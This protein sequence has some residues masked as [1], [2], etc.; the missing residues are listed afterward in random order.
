MTIVRQKIMPLELVEIH[1]NNSD[2]NLIDLAVIAKI[3]VNDARSIMEAHY[4]SA[5]AAKDDRGKFFAYPYYQLEKKR[6]GQTRKSTVDK[7]K[8]GFNRQEVL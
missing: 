8:H 3:S 7:Y 5:F 1:L 2:L 6:K 4:N